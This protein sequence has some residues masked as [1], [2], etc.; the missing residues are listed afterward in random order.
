MSFEKYV[1][2]FLIYS[3]FTITEIFKEDIGKL[4]QNCY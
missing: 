3:Y 4:V 2:I 1:K